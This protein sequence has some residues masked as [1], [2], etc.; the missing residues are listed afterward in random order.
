MAG[1]TGGPGLFPGVNVG[2]T[3]AVFEQGARHVAK[4]I[5]G[6]GVA[7][8]SAA[9]LSAAMMLRHLNLPGFS[10]RCG[11]R[12]ARSLPAALCTVVGLLA[13][14]RPVSAPPCLMRARNGHV[15]SASEQSWAGV[16]TGTGVAGSAL[17][18]SA[19]S[20]RAS[21]DDRSCPACV[22]WSGPYWTQSAMSQTL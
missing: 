13:C 3:V 12:R 17:R 10:D 8:P 19:I 6:M 4:D 11:R 2:E 22:G 20:L 14:K 5:A 21:A 9:L 15:V 18:R 7:N 16:A 1:L